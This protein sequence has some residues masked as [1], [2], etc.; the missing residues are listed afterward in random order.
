MYYNNRRD[1][2]SSSSRGELNDDIIACDIT[3][4]RVAETCLF[5]THAVLNWY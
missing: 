1:D 4:Y 3:M 5:C 2:I